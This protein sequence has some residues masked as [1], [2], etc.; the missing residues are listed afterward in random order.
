MTEKAPMKTEFAP[1][2]RDDSESVLE[3]SAFLR[4]NH[5]PGDMYN[6]LNTPVM[7]LN[8]S[9]QV[10]FA[11]SALLKL[12]GKEN[13][14]D[15]CGLRPGELVQCVHASESAG[16]CGTTMFCRE[17]GAVQ[18]IL[19]SQQQSEQNVR[20]CRI[21]T[22]NGDALNLRVCACKLLFAQEEYTVFAI[23]DVSDM[24]RRRF[25]ERIFF[26]DLMNTAIG[27]RGLCELLSI[28]E[29]NE[30]AEFQ[31]RLSFSSNVL[32]DE[33]ESQ[34][35]LL[36]VESNELEVE[37][38]PLQVADILE[39]VNAVYAT[40]EV[41]QNR[42]LIVVPPLPSLLVMSDKALLSRVVGN[43]VK[44]ALEA[45]EE[46]QT[47]M[48]KAEEHHGRVLFSVHNETVMPEF[49]QLQL[50]QRSFSTKGS[51]RGLGTYSMKII[52]ERYLDGR[53]SFVSTPEEGTTFFA[54]YPLVDAAK[55]DQQ[56]DL[57]AEDIHL[58]LR[59]LLAEDNP[60]QAR[61]VQK[62][63]AGSGCSCE[64]ARNGQ[65]MLEWLEKESFDVVLMDVEMPVMGGDEATRLMVER[66]AKDARPVIVAMT[67]HR[68]RDYIDQC[69]E[70]GMDHYVHKPVDAAELLNLLNRLQ[71]MR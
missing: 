15:V 50:F 60:F 67:A 13:D 33:I 2:E 53:I 18:A 41:A 61:V 63:L 27:V 22:Q 62:M 14:C 12:L 26:H 66:Y 28:A 24:Q 38:H 58:S 10:V 3:Q 32:V 65:D 37:L 59:V 42:T 1:A 68:T 48:A 21:L 39:D 51:G 57:A 71:K 36:A 5:F 8:K 16:G 6:A 31:K 25:L 64:H 47:V 44:N 30:L 69:L 4:E 56:L 43:M 49:V 46:G 35:E 45:S 29:I 9:R 17:C 7:I 19:K 70:A 40:H 55:T 34:R 54:E 52:S 23:E 11:N 20:E